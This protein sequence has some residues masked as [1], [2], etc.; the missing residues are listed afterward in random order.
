M[1][2]PP[3]AP[4]TAKMVSALLLAGALQGEVQAQAFPPGIHL[5]SLSGADG[6]RLDGAAAKDFS[7]V[8]VSTAGDRNGDGLDD[9]IVGALGADP[10]GSDSGS[11]DVVFGRNTV[12]VFKNGLE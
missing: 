12:P 10:N 8:S 9:L 4:D 7:G 6:F 3:E 5:G 1:T 2:P 11:S